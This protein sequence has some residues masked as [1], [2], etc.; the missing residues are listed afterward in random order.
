[1]AILADSS[2][3]ISKFRTEEP[4]M[5][6]FDNKVNFDW[7]KSIYGE[8]SEELPNNVPKSLGKRLL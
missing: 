7:S 5:S 8:H 1:M 3:L 2:I 4:K 6:Q